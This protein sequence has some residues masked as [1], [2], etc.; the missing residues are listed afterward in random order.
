MLKPFSILD[1][2]LIE[3]ISVLNII[4]KLFLKKYCT[5]AYDIHYDSF[6]I[7]NIR[8]IMYMTKCTLMCYSKSYKKVF[9]KQPQRGDIDGI[10]H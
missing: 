5:I 10:T 6:S 8:H 3:W 2:Y 4:D 1:D 9:R 7:R